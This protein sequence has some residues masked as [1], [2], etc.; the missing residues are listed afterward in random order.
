MSIKMQGMWLV[1][2]KSKTAAFAQEFKIEG[3]STGNGV[4]SGN[5]GTPEIFVNGSN[6]SIT[7]LN[8]PGSGF[9]PS[10]MQIKF[11]VALAGYYQFD[12]ESNDAGG[13]ADFNDLILTCRT[14][15]DANDYIVYGNVSYYEGFCLFNPCN[16]RYVVIDTAAALKEAIINPS[17]RKLI[18]AYYP[19][20][21]RDIDRAA[22]N[23]QPLPPAPGDPF[24]PM[25]IPLAD[26]AAIPAKENLMVKITPGSLQVNPDSKDRKEE[27]FTFNKLLSVQKTSAAS[28]ASSVSIAGLDKIRPDAIKIIDRYRFYC[29]SGAL[30]NAILSFKEYDRSGTELAGGPYT[31]DGERTALGDSFADRNGNYIFRF[32]TS[33]SDVIDEINTDTATGENSTV[34]SAPDVIVQLLCPGSIIPAF[35]TAPQWNISH[36]RRVNICVPKTKACLIPLAC[37][38]QHIIQGVGNIVFGPPSISGTRVGSGNFLNDR[39]IITAYGS[40][41]PQVRCAA[42]NGVLQLRGC[43]SNPQVKYYRLWY[44]SNTGFSLFTP[45]TEKFKLPR[46]EGVN[47]IDDEVFDA[48][49]NAY[50]NVETDTSRSWLIAYRN[51]KARI[52]TDAFT[53]GSYIFKIQGFTAAMAPVAGTEETVTL[54]LENQQ[55]SAGI[56]PEIQMEGVGLLG[57]C[58]LFTLPKVGETVTE[59]AGLTVK[60]KAIH[61]PGTAVG[62]MNSYA[63]SMAKGASGFSFTPPAAPAN[64]TSPGV[65][66]TVIN[67]GRTYMHGSDLNCITY[68][69]GTEN[70]PTAD[71]DG[72][73]TVTLHPLSGHWLEPDQPFCAFGIYLNGN[74]RLTN[75][76]SGYPNFYGG[77]VLIGIQRP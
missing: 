5:P 50:I 40:G 3:A 21:V 58:A 49:Q 9:I 45:F 61:K 64:F 30:P 73:Y 27:E 2:V 28:S 23:P 37:N 75:G 7:I 60:F 71:G 26:N 1:R 14:P 22:L 10:E 77:Q 70:E 62:F 6:W 59:N 63:L 18:S 54:Y 24:V 15:I 42:W 35:E 69:H 29:E 12:I 44:R 41:A 55:L 32:R 76:E 11:P 52:N 25:V 74:L 16:P 66:D 46:F 48:A 38:G 13:D 31:G 39:G 36:L 53:P 65:L 57:E 72:N 4:Y 19:N 43:L 8:N 17:L 56:D 33:S 47:V 20:R 67:S 51:I 68:F 34:Q